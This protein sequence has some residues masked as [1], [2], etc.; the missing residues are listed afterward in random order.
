MPIRLTPTVKWLLIINLAAYVLQHTLELVTG[1]HLS[2]YLGLVPIKAVLNFWIWQLFT[3]PFL[4]G[5]P[6]HLFL[7]LMMLAFLGSDLE[8]IWGKR[9]FI[10]FYI[11]CGLTAGISYL[12]IQIFV[13]GGLTSP[14]V[15]ASG[16]IFGLLLA[17]GILFSERTLLFMMLF[18]MKAKHFVW[19]L[20]GM[21]LMT[22]LYSPDG[23]GVSSV[24]HLGGMVGAII[25][26]WSVAYLSKR[27]K[28]P[29]TA[30]RR[31]RDYLKLVVDNNRDKDDNDPG[32]QTWH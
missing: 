24:A 18:P 4:H 5:P 11:F 29:R 8:S 20:A 27:A 22:L 1:V 6:W 3:Y 15:G 13:S 32:K 31:A 7:N 19:I 12:L 9:R 2:Q 21:E 30:G 23:G 28:R 25:Y 14:L 17:Y 10:I 16:A 26:L